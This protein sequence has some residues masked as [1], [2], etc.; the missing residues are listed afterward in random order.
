MLKKK[1]LQ[2]HVWSRLLRERLNEPLHLNLL[3]LGVAAFGGFRS[4]VEMDLVLRPH[5]AW[6]ILFAADQAKQ[7]GLDGITVVE[8]GVAAGTGLMNMASIA[9]RVSTLIGVSIDVVGFDSGVGMPAPVDYRDHPDLYSTGDFPMSSEHL[10]KSLPQNA[11]LILGPIDSSIVDF[12]GA[13][14]PKMPVGYA[15]VDVDYYSST[16]DCL[17]LFSS[18]SPNL[19]LPMTALYLDDVYAFEHNTRCG[20]LLAI[21]EFNHRNPLRLIEKSSFLKNKRVF[22]RAQWIDQ[23]YLLHLLDHDVRNNPRVGAQ[24]VISNPYLGS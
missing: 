14:S 9:E 21:E 6:A 5:N 7:L 19:F 23:I 20:E 18:V 24:Q 22:S 16:V 8:F 17:S 10:V 12:A 3:S 15:V 11:R 1:L 4:K 2:R 13:L